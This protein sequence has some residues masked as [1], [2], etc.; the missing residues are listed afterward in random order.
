[1]ANRLEV[2]VRNHDG[3]VE[4][5]HTF[6]AELVA[7]GSAARKSFNAAR[8]AARKAEASPS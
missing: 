2:Q 3:L 6:P 7:S 4:A 8:A 1:M 5:I